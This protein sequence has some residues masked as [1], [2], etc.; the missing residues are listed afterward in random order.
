[1]HVPRMPQWNPWGHA[2]VS[3]ILKQF[4][5]LLSRGGGSVI[6]MIPL[7]CMCFFIEGVILIRM[8]RVR[9]GERKL[10]GPVYTNAFSFENASTEDKALERYSSLERIHF[11]L[12]K[13]PFFLAL[14]RWN[15][16]FHRLIHFSAFKPFVH[17]N[18][19][20]VFIENASIWKRPWE[21]IKTKTHR[22]R[23]SVD[24][25]KRNKTKWKR[26]SQISEISQARVFVA[27]A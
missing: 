16:C 4:F 26:W 19:Q 5:R 21:W 7:C 3:E 25:W 1:M 14:R 2:S 27:C 22:N 8:K 12:R 17:A 6:L 13:Q 11:S 24:G 18:T 9:N 10:L 23:I 20:S 15:G